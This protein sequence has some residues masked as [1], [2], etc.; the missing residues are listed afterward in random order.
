MSRLSNLLALVTLSIFLAVAG[1]T[2]ATTETETKS[3]EPA[4]PQMTLKETL[5]KTSQLAA[6]LNQ[7]FADGA[8]HDV[9]HDPLHEISHLLAGL[10]NRI[11]MS[12]LTEETKSALATSVDALMDNYGKIDAKFHGAEGADFADV[13]DKITEAL[14]SLDATIESMK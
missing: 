13:K 7:G 10:P 3:E 8:G 14:G 4:A 1:C 12:D 5:E 11:A 2:P 9:V 6:K